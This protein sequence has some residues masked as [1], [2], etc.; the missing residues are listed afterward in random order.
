MNL[1]SYEL[2]YLVAAAGL[3]NLS[4]PEEEP[5]KAKELKLLGAQMRIETE[6]MDEEDSREAFRGF[7]ELADKV[8]VTIDTLK[9]KFEP[10]EIDSE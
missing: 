8:G 7:F 5:E 10:E 1:T 9:T 4:D 3:G 6:E 2:G